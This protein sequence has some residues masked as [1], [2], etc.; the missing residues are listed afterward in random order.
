MSKQRNRRRVT[1][2]GAREDQRRLRSK[3]PAGIGWEQTENEITITTGFAHHDG[4][5]AG[6]V[7][8]FKAYA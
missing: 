2:S 1:N 7:S 8:V 4:G 6:F 3:I 5:R